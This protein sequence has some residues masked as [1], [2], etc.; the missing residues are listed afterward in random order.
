MVKEE[1]LKRMNKKDKGWNIPYY[2]FAKNTPLI[3]TNERR[4][5]IWNT[6]KDLMSIPNVIY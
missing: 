5:N 3:M 2:F 1:I 4:S 6:K